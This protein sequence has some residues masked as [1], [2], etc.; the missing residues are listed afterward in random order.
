V[1]IARI[2]RLP[3][4]LLLRR[5]RKPVRKLY[6]LSP[7]VTP[8]VNVR[9]M[10]EDVYTVSE[11]A[12]ILK[13]GEHRIRQMLREGQLEG[14]QDEISGR[15]FADKRAVHSLKEER[16]ARAP[17]RRPSEAA[18]SPV[19]AREWAERVGELAR[20]LG[21]VEGEFRARTEL[22]EIT[23]STLRESLERERERA[24]RLEAALEEERSKSFWRKLFG[25]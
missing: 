19:E 18:R 3:R 7:D 2:S 16:G 10:S 21:R 22:S 8:C 25:G 11:A 15:W 20:E 24:D 1:T 14:R 23:E 4:T 6:A 17:A 12:R 5:D 9:V 13:L